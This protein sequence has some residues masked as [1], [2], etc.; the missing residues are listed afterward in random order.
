MSD[1]TTTDHML[2]TF[3]VISITTRPHVDV[4]LTD[5]LV[6]VFPCFDGSTWPFGLVW[7]QHSIQ[8]YEYIDM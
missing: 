3:F 1:N 6:E 5:Q 8:L 2:D 7:L 4:P